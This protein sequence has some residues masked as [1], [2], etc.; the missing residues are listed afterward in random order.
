[1]G[2]D[3]APTDGADQEQR[4]HNVQDDIPVV[5]KPFEAVGHNQRAEQAANLAG[6]CSW[7]R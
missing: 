4:A 1:M 2:I 7:P 5:I 6:Q 3:Q